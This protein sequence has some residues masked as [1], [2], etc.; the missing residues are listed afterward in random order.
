MA[1]YIDKST[2]WT[3]TKEVSY[4]VTPVIDPVADFVELINPSIDATTEMIDREILKNSM[5]MAQPL[6]GKETTSG[7]MEVEL[8]SVTTLGKLNGDLLYESAMGHRI[9]PVVGSAGA[10]VD[11]LD[12]T[13]T[14]TFTVAADADNYEVGQ[15]IK[16]TGGAGDA[17]FAVVRSITAGTSM[18]IAPVPAAVDHVSF[19]GL[20]SYTIAKPTDPQISLT[21]QEYM[22]SGAS[23]VEYTYNGVVV[24]DLGISFPVAN[25]VKA[26]FSVGGAGFGI[27]EDG[28]A[29]GVVAA[30]N[31]QCTDFA[32]YVAKNMTFMYDGAS[33]DVE[34][35][36]VN[37]TSEIYDTEALTTAGI[38]NKTATGKS[39]VGGTFGLEY[40][41]TTLFSKF[42]AGTTG[43]L[44]GVVKNNDTASGIYAPK[45][46][47]T[48]SSKST[49]SGIYKESLS[50]ACL[51]SDLCS[52][53][54]EDAITLFFE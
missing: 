35:L 16:M 7:S 44:W 20:L 34:S 23:R 31:A 22:E 4:G 17:E 21:I 6:L 19:E 25:I 41:G 29:G 47:L 48:E 38:T 49:D 24:S 27:E 36:E 53:T 52:S 39:T 14:V 9:A 50:Y 37:V 54:S 51:S 13:A 3:V 45:V 46:V 42:K 8:A 40:K 43:E 32:P 26:N 30:R 15:A 12:G 18:V 28:V 2:Q 33:Y 1:T 5:V 10:V 11:N